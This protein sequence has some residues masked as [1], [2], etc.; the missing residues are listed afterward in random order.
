[1]IS[2]ICTMSVDVFGRQLMR[3]SLAKNGIPGGRGPP[4]QGFKLTADGQYDI[5]H[6]RLCNLADPIEQTDA[7]SVKVMQ[8]AIQQEVRLTYNIT[9]S[10]RGNLDDHEIMIRGLEK[11]LE[12]YI[13]NQ[14]VNH[15]TLEDLTTRNSQ[16]IV[17]LDERLRALEK[18]RS[19]NDKL[20]IE[21]LESS[22][23]Q[24]LKRIEAEYKG[25]EELTHRNSQVIALLDERL[26]TLENGARTK[27]P[28]V[29]AP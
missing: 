2:T 14:S 6:K 29:G 21:S 25:T 5:D 8:S 23:K 24:Q 18:S 27:D 16:L 3:R 19:E 11:N 12:A 22:V 9:S 28:G 7:V 15:E 1:M 17:H 10:M 20:M 26:N 4:G 13:K